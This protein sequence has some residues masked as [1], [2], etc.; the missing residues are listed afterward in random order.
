MH[1]QLLSGRLIGEGMNSIDPSYTC[2][3]LLKYHFIIAMTF[4]FEML[5]SWRLII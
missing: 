1:F 5:I 3:Q 4:K 2:R